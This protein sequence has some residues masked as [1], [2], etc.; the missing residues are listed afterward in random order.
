MEYIYTFN[1]ANDKLL[2][3][4]ITKCTARDKSNRYK[5]IDEILGDLQDVINNENE[6]IERAD[7]IRNL[8]KGILTSK[9]EQYIRKLIS[10]DELCNCIVRYKLRDFGKIIIQVP[11][12]EMTEIMRNLE[13]GYVEST[14]Y[15]QFANY[16]IYGDIAYYVYTNTKDVEIKKIAKNILEVCASYRWN[17]QKLLDRINIMEI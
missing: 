16:D 12:L 14:G 8:Q 4:I 15:M 2:D 9:E 1:D 17:V 7:I 6:E 5:S 11:I 3:Y 10:R 13:Q